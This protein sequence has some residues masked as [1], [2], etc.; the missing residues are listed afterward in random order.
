MATQSSLKVEYW[1]FQILLGII[2]IGLGI[3]FMVTPLETYVA[4]AVLFSFAMLATGFFEI[5]NSINVKEVS[6]R[7][8]LYF[9]GGIID[10]ILGI[11]LIKNE[12]L[13]LRVLPI[14]LGIWF[15]IRA[16]LFL[17]LYF[18]F[19]QEYK[20]ESVWVLLFAILTLLFSFAILANPV[21]GKIIIV[22]T[23]SLAFL[24]MGLF[25]LALGGTLYQSRKRRINH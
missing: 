17:M 23:V 6:K 13:N 21:L 15:L 2:S 20:N 24:F 8:I 5:I 1:W 19:R 25:R 18:E 12:D 4:F 11:I 22:Y 9:I 7:W 14:L 3:R 10:I 16:I